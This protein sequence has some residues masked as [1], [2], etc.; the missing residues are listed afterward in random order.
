MPASEVLT[1]LKAWKAK[2]RNKSKDFVNFALIKEAMEGELRNFEEVSNEQVDDIMYQCRNYL[3]KDE[4]L[5]KLKLEGG[6]GIGEND[7]EVRCFYCARVL[8]LLFSFTLT[9]VRRHRI[10]RRYP[11][12]SA[13][14]R[15]LSC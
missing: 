11:R 4:Q 10:R 7:S 15:A 8:A 13:C 6:D 2:K 14:T 12:S 1:R 9:M 5:S 3:R